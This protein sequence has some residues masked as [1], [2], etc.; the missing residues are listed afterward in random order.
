VW[1]PGLLSPHQAALHGPSPALQEL[2]L[3][4]PRKVLLTPELLPRTARLAS[5]VT[6][7]LKEKEVEKEKTI[8][9]IQ[10]WG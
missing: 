8:I 4:Y 3:F 9:K 7:S 2:V 1:P 5:S 10:K 6:H